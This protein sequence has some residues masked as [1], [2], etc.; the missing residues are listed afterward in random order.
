MRR[1]PRVNVG[2][3]GRAL[4]HLFSNPTVLVVPLVA[5]VIDMLVSYW[6]G[7]VTDPLGGYGNSIFQMI[8]QI[9]YLFAFGAAIVQA[10]NID[11]GHRGG[12]DEAWEETRRKTGGILLAAIGFQF[13]V[14]VAQYAGSL[15]GNGALQLVLQLIAYLF[16]IYTI[17]AAA[18]GGLPGGLALSGS[19]R[20]VRGN[21]LPSI[22]L[23]IVFVVLWVVVPSRVLFPL[24]A[25]LSPVVQLLSLALYRAIVLAYLA[26]P[27][28]VTY[29]DISFKRW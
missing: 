14:Y 9:I 1:G 28:A 16:L 7:V 22:I 3:Y 24:V 10:N 2:V 25:N 20:A 18:I 11:R 6:S 26:F 4:V 19:I 15:V 29:D 23:A 27:F 8:V 17:P 21:F 5:S 12:F 13:V